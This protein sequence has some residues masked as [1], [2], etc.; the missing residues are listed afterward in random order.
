LTNTCK[1][2]CMWAGNISITNPGNTAIAD[3][4]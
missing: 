1:C 4:K 3:V 2:M